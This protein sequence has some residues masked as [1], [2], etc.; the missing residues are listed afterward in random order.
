[1]ERTRIEQM[2]RVLTHRGPD[3]E[4]IVTRGPA[5]MGVRRLRVIDL[6]PGVQPI[7][8]EDG[9]IWAVQNGE[10]Y[11]Y[12][13]L[14]AFLEA[15][16]HHFRT[17]SD[18]EVL[19]HLYEEE[20]VELVQRLVGMFAF[21]LWDERTGTILLAGDRLG[22]KP[23]YYRPSS[24]YLS[25][26]SEIKALLQDDSVNP[27]PNWAVL[28]EYLSQGYVVSPNTMFRG[29]YKLPPG[30]ILTVREGRTVLKRYW[31]LPA[32]EIPG[33]RVGQGDSKALLGL[34]TEVIKDHMVSDVPLG[35]AFSGGIDSTAL[36][37]IIRR[38]LGF[39]VAT[40]T[41]GF[42]E[43]TFDERGHAAIAA[44]EFGTDHHEVL[45]DCGNELE[46]VLPRLVWHLD[47]P[48]ADSS[49]V[50][51][52]HLARE[53]RKDVTVLLGGDGGDELF[54]GYNRYRARR[55]ARWLLRWPRPLREGL[56]G[57]L[58]N[59]LP[60]TSAYYGSSR[61]TQ[62]RYL[63]DYARAIESSPGTTAL[64][65]FGHGELRALSP[66]LCLSAGQGAKVGCQLDGRDLDDL[67]RVMEI[68][69][70]TYLP[71]NVL[72][73]SDRMTMAVGLEMRAPLLDHRLV[74][75]V[76]RLPVGLRVN[77]WSTKVLLKRALAPLVSKDILRRPKHGFAV[78]VAD[79]LRGR[80]KKFAEPYLL[81]GASS[82]HGAF[83][84]EYIRCLWEAH[85]DGREN[86][87]NQLWAL[88]CFNLWYRSFIVEKR[89]HVP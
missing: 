60:H 77:S 45:V 83:D 16:G 6:T 20:G 81:G 36:V 49:A 17:V 84:R 48:C 34:L 37:A 12:R 58:V 85:Q 11:N 53:S 51:L 70:Q 31:S 50:P 69:L 72:F 27:E 15:K 63:L 3:E 39:S 21:A 73:R 9:M 23:L 57:G 32:G 43:A 59:R 7:A 86:W 67:S 56:L 35:V 47:E 52:F 42:Q 1:M 26:A 8:S 29:I 82:D 30:H 54:G 10:I 46:G 88:L 19:V 61:A 28:S 24:D 18:T 40:F 33:E 78:P 66:E 14:R 68:E 44:K 65:L 75:Y 62:I 25:F 55:W 38:C 13:E 89:G 80:L 76:A 41:V 64:P 79:W 74:E 22:Q 2:A 4:G 87:G 5:G 71:D